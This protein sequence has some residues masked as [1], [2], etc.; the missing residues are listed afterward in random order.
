MSFSSEMCLAY[1]LSVVLLH[2][3]VIAVCL[4]ACRRSQALE[5]TQMKRRRKET[6]ISC[7]CRGRQ[8]MHTHSTP[9]IATCIICWHTFVREWWVG[10]FESMIILSTRDTSGLSVRWLAKA[11]IPEGRVNLPPRVLRQHYYPW[12]P[13]RFVHSVGKPYPVHKGEGEYPVT[14]QTKLG[15]LTEIME[16]S[17]WYRY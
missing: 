11:A 4:P 16:I 15:A 17:I 1:Q 5:P 12:P 13:F 9:N 8:H 14:A 10:N 7:P 3:L 6:T 2:C